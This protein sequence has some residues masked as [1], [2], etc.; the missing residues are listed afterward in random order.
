MVCKHWKSK[1]WCRLGSSCKFL[2]PEHKR[3]ASAPQST[4]GVDGA[5]PPPPMA[6]VR[7]KKRGGKNRSNRGQH[8]HLGQ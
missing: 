7:R 8:E 3:G 6:L 1:G 2:H 5:I 4:I